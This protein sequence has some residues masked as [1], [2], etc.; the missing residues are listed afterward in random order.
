MRKK[1]LEK[2]GWIAVAELMDRWKKYD[3]SS[4]IGIWE[5]SCFLNCPIKNL[6][7]TSS[8][9]G[10]ATSVAFEKAEEGRKS[11]MP[12]HG[13][14][15]LY[16]KDGFKWISIDASDESGAL[17]LYF[18]KKGTEPAWLLDAYKNKEE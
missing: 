14:A 17:W 16:E 4:F 6:I 5:A 18:W 7:T 3:W 2:R 13:E 12:C 15:W 1:E 8:E 11:P 9:E 10:L